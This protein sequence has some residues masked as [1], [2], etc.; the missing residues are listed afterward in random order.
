MLGLTAVAMARY[1]GA[2]E[3]IAIDIIPARLKK[4][5]EFGATKTFL[6]GEDSN[7]ISDE[8]KEIT[9]GLGVDLIIEMTGL[10]ISM[11]NGIHLLTIGGRYVFV[12]AVFP[13]RP[14]ALSAEMIVR[15]LLTIHGL[16]N[17]IPQDLAEAITF[18]SD[19]YTQYPFEELTSKEFSLEETNEAFQYSIDNKTYRVAIVNG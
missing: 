9:D 14:I 3:V 6:A 8:V 19:T 2:K 10:P 15:N 5:T 18:L 4:A 12:G 1:Y 11:E 13:N 7:K 17:Y 16:H